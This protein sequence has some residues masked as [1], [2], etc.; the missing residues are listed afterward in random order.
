MEVL[1]GVCR[2]CN[3]PKT[4]SD[5]FIKNGKPYTHGCKQCQAASVRKWYRENREKALEKN[6]SYRQ[7]HK[8]EIYRTHYKRLTTV[9]AHK[10]K[11]LYEVKQAVIKGLF[12]KLPCEECGDFKTH[13]HHTNGY[14]KDN[15]F[16]GKWL[17]HYHHKIAHGHTP[18]K[19]AKRK[20]TEEE[21]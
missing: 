12:E 1:D 5:L 19:L 6:E 10:T 18:V 20:E 16:T 13:F 11:A 17:C 15:W 14:D 2:K 4:Q 9:D 7:S 21:K 3:E 8:K